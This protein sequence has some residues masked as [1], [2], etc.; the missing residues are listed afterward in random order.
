M[1][2]TASEYTGEQ[3]ERSLRVQKRR[4]CQDGG[5]GS[6]DG[7]PEHDALVH[8]P[9]RVLE[10]GVMAWLETDGCR[11]LFSGRAV[12]EPVYV[13]DKQ[14]ECLEHTRYVHALP[15]RMFLF[16]TCAS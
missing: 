2:R 14:V 6:D 13:Y 1:K 3:A 5:V 9:E 4:A 15:R 16:L 8:L 10:R 12:R 11:D 7:V